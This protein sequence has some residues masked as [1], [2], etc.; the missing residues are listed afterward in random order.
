M[1]WQTRLVSAFAAATFAALVPACDLFCEDPD[2]SCGGSLERDSPECSTEISSGCNAAQYFG[3]LVVDLPP[4]A[5]GSFVLEGSAD[6]E[7]YSCP[8][9]VASGAPTLVCPGWAAGWGD[10]AEFRLD[11]VPCTVS[12]ALR[13]GEGTVI[14]SG[15]FRPDY[16]WDEPNGKGCGW[17]GV[18]RVQ[19]ARR[20]ADRGAARRGV[21]TG[22]LS[23]PIQRPPA[24]TTARVQTLRCA[25]VVEATRRCRPRASRLGSGTPSI[26]AVETSQKIASAALAQLLAEAPQGVGQ[27]KRLKRDGA[28]VGAFRT[29]LPSSRRLAALQAQAVALTA[30]RDEYKRACSELLG[31][32]RKLEWGSL[33][34]SGGKSRPR[35]PGRPSK[36][37]ECCSAASWSPNRRCRCRPRRRQRRRTRLPGPLGS[38]PDG[39][40]F[41]ITCR[42]LGSRSSRQRAST[43][44]SGS[45]RPSARRSRE[46]P[47]R[48][49]RA[50][51]P[52][53]VRAQGTVSVGSKL[54]SDNCVAPWGDVVDVEQQAAV[55]T[56]MGASG[57]PARAL[58]D[59]G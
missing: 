37:S 45:A 5:D 36:S 18:G 27:T 58:Y 22:V 12:I 38:P 25:H 13:T 15:D 20:M 39:G 51:H 2:L 16:R 10:D 44:S 56:H 43:P 40:R 7:P 19:L 53:E 33:V 59:G 50:V 9:T 34:S 35:I 55:R 11:S 42:A 23:D 4:L 28:S 1:A 49:C 14:A 32:C 24:G 48:T 26:P 3:G 17:V 54:L 52:T 47:R 8:L 21:A 31:K 29:P 41:L 46:G 30:K 57:G 6:G